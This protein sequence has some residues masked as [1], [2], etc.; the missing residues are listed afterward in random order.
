MALSLWLGLYVVSRS[1]R[2]LMAWLTGLTL[3]TITRLFLDV[4][5]ALNPPPMPADEAD[6]LRL[7]FP[8]W[9]AVILKEQGATGWLQG[10]S[11]TSAVMFWH[12]VTILIRPGPLTP[13]RWTRIVIGYGVAV[14]WVVINITTPYFFSS[15]VGDPLYLNTLKAGPV[16]PFFAVFLLL[17]TVMSVTNLARSARA[18]PTTMPRKQ[19]IILTIATVVGGLASPLTIA[20][21]EFGL[22]MPVL[23]LALILGFY[24]ILIGYGVAGYSALMDGRTIRHDFFYNAA[25]VGL[26]TLLYLVVT[27]VSVQ[28]YNIPPVAFVFVVM[29]AVITHTSLDVARHG[30]D[31][32]FYRR[33]TRRLR[34]NLRQLATLAGEQADQ[35]KNLS[36]ALDSLCASVQATFGLIVLFEEDQL[37]VAATCHRPHFK[38][39]LLPTD[40]A[41]DDVLFL[42]PGHFPVP[43]TEAALLM[44]LYADM[45][46]VGALLLGQPKNGPSYSKADVE[47]LLYPSDWLADII[48]NARRE[49]EFLAR[50]ADLTEKSQLE[51]NPYPAQISVK[52]VENALRNL[53][54]YAHLGE[55]PLSKMKLVKSRLPAGTVTHLDRGKVVYGVLAEAVGKLKPDDQHPSSPPP[56]E[57][58]AYLILHE[59]YFENVLNRDIMARLYISEGT[60]NRT[61]R[62]ALRAVAKTLE[63]METGVN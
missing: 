52:A 27:W 54:N 16:Y 47:L 25:M 53:A 23:I 3:W 59:S 5:L 44:P 32:L 10:W 6:W 19:L 33:D 38:L 62:A 29:L 36:L 8:F 2:S 63:E 41:A 15:T 50:I 56:R 4:I 26:V 60:F 22:P 1:P 35:E 20:A 11:M 45:T 30:L 39:D 17:Y 7:F 37:R 18:A 46:Q 14:A 42:K 55:H 61:R 58:Y 12:H 40:L 48:Q 9:R 43:L 13:W 24:V 57:W 34:E 49:S 51:V 21:S 28:A 31:S